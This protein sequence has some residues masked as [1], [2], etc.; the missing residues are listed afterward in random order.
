MSQLRAT[1]SH[2]VSNP[3]GVQARHLAGNGVGILT[4]VSVIMG[5]TR[6]VSEGFLSQVLFPLFLKEGS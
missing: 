5:I 2:I 3:S 6:F 1:V 4:C